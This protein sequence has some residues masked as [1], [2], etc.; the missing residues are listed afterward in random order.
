MHAIIIILLKSLKEFG[1][2]SSIYLQIQCKTVALAWFVSI[3][4]EQN[5]G[6]KWTR[7]KRTTTTKKGTF[8]TPPILPPFTQSLQ[9]FPPLLHS[10]PPSNAFKSISTSISR[11]IGKK[12]LIFFCLQG[13]TFRYFFERRGTMLG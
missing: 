5:G 2:K 9:C 1:K 4:S 10:V 13:P 7:G 3:E 6:C 11:S 12:G 8:P